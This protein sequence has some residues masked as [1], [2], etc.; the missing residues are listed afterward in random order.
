[1]KEK[2]DYPTYMHIVS[3]WQG[4]ILKR[5]GIFNLTLIIIY[6]YFHKKN[7]FV[8]AFFFGLYV[9]E[10]VWKLSYTF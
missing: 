8:D 6:Q 1:M 4:A 10:I 7:P 2:D 5:K 9:R 3:T